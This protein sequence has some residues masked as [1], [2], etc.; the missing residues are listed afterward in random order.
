MTFIC[1]AP[2]LSRRAGPGPT[3]LLAVE[4]V[5]LDE[6]AQ[7]VE[8]RMIAVSVAAVATAAHQGDDEVRHVMDA[9]QEAL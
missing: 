4:T 2:R 3:A 7:R 9:Q 6:F 5:V 1:V 8:R